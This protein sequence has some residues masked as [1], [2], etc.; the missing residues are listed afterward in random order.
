MDDAVAAA[1]LALGWPSGPVNVC[2]DDPAAGH[3]WVPAFCAAVGA[4]PPPVTDDRAPWARGADNRRARA[5]GW[6]P[7]HPWRETLGG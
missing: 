5:L 4:P 2:D 6:A 1:V 7:R 3:G